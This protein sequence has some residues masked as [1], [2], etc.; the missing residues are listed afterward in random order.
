[1]TKRNFRTNPEQMRKAHSAREVNRYPRVKAISPALSGTINKLGQTLPQEV[2]DAFAECTY[3]ERSNY[4]HE[5]IDKGWTQASIGRAC[6]LSRE[7]IRQISNATKHNTY[8]N[9][10]LPEPPRY[11]IAQKVV[12]TEPPA[13]MLERLKELQPYAQKVRSSSPKFRAEA[14]EYTYLLNEATKL[15]T[16]VYRLG[17]L[18]GIT[19]SAIQFRLVRYGYRA[20]EGESRSYTK[21]VEKNKLNKTEEMVNG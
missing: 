4:I 16:T 12:Y 3:E 1:M 15:G 20:S 6:G 13:E 8:T 14:E 5:L 2:V 18:L 10:P 19:P 21:I 7:S 17:K 11:P 9:Y